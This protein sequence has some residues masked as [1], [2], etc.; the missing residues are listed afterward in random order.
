MTAEQILS[1]LVRIPSVN[2][3]DKPLHSNPAFG[4]KRLAEHIAAL[5]NGMD[6]PSSLS[7][8]APGRYSLFA[9]VAGKNP[10][11]KLL[12]NVHL[13]TVSAE[14][15]TVDPFGAEVRDGRL[16]GRGATDDKGPAAALLLALRQLWQR[17][18]KPRST[19]HLL[20][21]GDEE[22]GTLGTKKFLENG[23]RC[24][25]CIMM[26]P[27]GLDIVI[28]HNGAAQWDIRTLGRAV[29]SS[30]AHEGENAITRMGKLLAFIEETLNPELADLGHPLCG[31]PNV[32]VGIISGGREHNTV[33]DRCVATLLTRNSPAV[34][35]Q[36]FMEMVNTR[37]Q[38][39]AEAN[40][41]RLEISG[42]CLLTDGLN[43][44]PD[45]P[46]IQAVR[47]ALLSRGY[48]GRLVGKPYGTDA[49]LLSP[50]HIPTIV[51][52]PGSDLDCH[53]PD[54]SISLE[55]VKRAAQVLA[56]ILRIF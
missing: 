52:G 21:A 10:E 45:E 11:R 24:D 12:F 25:A 34:S 37:L 51:F 55:E 20:F 15:M 3:G 38:E 36:E 53:T 48:P 50:A 8:F 42:D 26:E 16:Y 23:Y 27:T 5:L 47:E 18:E 28:A 17:G 40:G 39:F 43:T 35:S 33:P 49:Y 4:E 29:H 31:Q 30:R 56:D 14:G 54:E 2:P 19:I 32:N 1:S 44:S 46:V 9:A 22:C 6:I 7:E 13:D 41:I